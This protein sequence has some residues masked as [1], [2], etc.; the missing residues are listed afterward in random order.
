MFGNQLTPVVKNLLIANFFVFALTVFAGMTLAE[1]FGL[2]FVVGKDFQAFQIITY[3][4][5]HGGLHHILSN[6][7][8]LLIFGPVLEQRFGSQ[9]FLTFYLVC[10]I[11]AGLLHSLF[12]LVQYF[13][14]IQDVEA[15]L[16]APDPDA[17]I[18]F[19]ESS[20]MVRWRESVYE[21]VYETFPAFP[22]DPNYISRAT[23]IVS[24]YAKLRIE[25]FNVPMIG[26]SGAIFG[27][28]MGFGLLY[29]ERK[30]FLLFPP[31][32]VKAKYLVLFY[33]VYELA[34]LYQQRPNDNIAHLAHLGGMLMAFILI[35]IWKNKI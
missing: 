24:Q 28:L 3:M 13:L 27:I 19:V 18:S 31:M 21:F 30:F 16:A 8:G 17:L 26:A 4:F 15:F 14:M 35:R 32:I 33:G 9:R 5:L 22:Q 23:D 29:P 12:N 1:N 25:H 20:S 34:S 11:G 7:F 10:G 2:R 6:M